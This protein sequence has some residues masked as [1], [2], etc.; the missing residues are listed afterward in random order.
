M[1]PAPALA[2]PDGRSG[3]P[4]VLVAGLVKRYGDRIAL[5]GIGFTVGAG[6]IFGLLGLNGA[7]KSTTLEILEGLRRPDSGRAE[8][9][10]AD[11]SGS[12]RAVARHVGVMLQSTELPPRLR[13][14]EAVEL[15]AALQGC[16]SD[17]S[18]VLARVGLEDRRATPF[19]ALSGGER[20]RLALGLAL[21]HDPQVLLL[22]EPTAGLDVRARRE[23]HRLLETLRALGKS[24][25]LTTHHLDEAERLCDRV[26]ILH[27]G[28]ILACA[29]PAE[30]V[31]RR[32]RPA[33]GSS[34]SAL[35]EALVALTAEAADE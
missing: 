1:N 25:L 12:R 21:V 30:I 29:A 13:A 32:A 4:A 17:P 27:R 23:L 5:D 14:G 24:V 9:L 3:A 11:I 33:A 15:F 34:G 20:Q 35:E 8:I 26:A 7:G 6:E 2:R 31:A 16:A 19:R 22:D 28:R 18:D 10:G